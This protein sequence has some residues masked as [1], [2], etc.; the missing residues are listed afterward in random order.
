M[1]KNTE[2]HYAQVQSVLLLALVLLQLL[3]QQKQL[4]QRLA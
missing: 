2:Q 4:N 1:Y 3:D